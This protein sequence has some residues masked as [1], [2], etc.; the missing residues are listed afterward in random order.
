MTTELNTTMEI[1]LIKLKIKD[2]KTMNLRFLGYIDSSI[3]DTDAIGS[4]SFLLLL[5]E[6][7]ISI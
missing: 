3:N 6:R 4:I 2:T 1:E 5:T 7:T